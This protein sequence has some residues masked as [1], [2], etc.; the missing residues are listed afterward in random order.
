MGRDQHIDLLRNPADVIGYNFEDQPLWNVVAARR[1]S[2]PHPSPRGG[3]EQA[4][5]DCVAATRGL[6][7]ATAPASGG[8]A[9][10]QLRYNFDFAAAR[11]VYAIP[12]SVTGWR[13]L[14]RWGPAR[15]GS[16]TRRAGLRAALPVARRAAR[17]ARGGRLPL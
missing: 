3:A 16:T 7:E 8:T 12:A 5:T 15:C 14:F 11:P 4:P 1:A 13:S 6:P 9:R 10:L 17:G 2:K